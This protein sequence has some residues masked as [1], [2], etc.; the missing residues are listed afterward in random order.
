MTAKVRKIS[1]VVL[2]LFK[3]LQEVLVFE[4]FELCKK[5]V[6]WV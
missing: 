6:I 3:Y 5:G 4:A 2:I 1:R